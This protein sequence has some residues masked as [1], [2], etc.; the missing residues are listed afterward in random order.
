MVVAAE[1]ATAAAV[2]FFD[3]EA[4]GWTEVGT[5]PETET[6]VG[7][8]T[9]TEVETEVGTELGRVWTGAGIETITGSGTGFG[10]RRR[11]RFARGLG[12]WSI[13]GLA[14]G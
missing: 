14:R 8:E 6:E 13:R 7:T 2:C 4:E 11:S 5:E 3:F 10:S 1:V 12:H 9:E